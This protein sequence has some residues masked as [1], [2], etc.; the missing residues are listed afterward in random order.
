MKKKYCITT[1]TLATFFLLLSIKLHGQAV[2][3]SD[4]MLM[5][6]VFGSNIFAIDEQGGTTY[7]RQIDLIDRIHP[8]N[9]V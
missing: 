4:R 6:E 1:L 5:V 2:F 3:G 7:Q 9:L 8:T